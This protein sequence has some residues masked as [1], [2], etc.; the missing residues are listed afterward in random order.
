MVNDMQIVFQNSPVGP[1]EGVPDK[2]YL[3][4]LD[5]YINRT[6]QVYTAMEAAAS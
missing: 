2:R 6:R 1:K 5:A 3:D 4:K